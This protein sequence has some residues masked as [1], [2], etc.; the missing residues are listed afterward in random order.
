MDA[1]CKYSLNEVVGSAWVQTSEKL[2]RASLMFSDQVS[3]TNP[4]SGIRM[5]YQQPGYTAPNMWGS[6]GLP[7]S[8][9]A[10]PWRPTTGIFTGPA[11]TWVKIRFGDPDRSALIWGMV[12]MRQQVEA[13]TQLNIKLSTQYFKDVEAGV[14][15]D[16]D[17]SGAAEGMRHPNDII[18]GSYDFTVAVADLDENGLYFFP[19][20]FVSSKVYID[21]DAD[22]YIN[23][24]F[25]GSFFDF[26]TAS[27]G[28]HPADN[29]MDDFRNHGIGNFFIAGDFFSTEL[30]IFCRN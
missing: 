18:A 21:I 1:S 2:L 5:R 11:D 7:A 26:D 19:F 12:F 9:V 29:K 20:M 24:D 30:L 14:Y 16:T 10:L 22:D 27:T 4:G 17:S 28:Q 23:F 13:K 25:L 6:S 15:P 3:V 8:K